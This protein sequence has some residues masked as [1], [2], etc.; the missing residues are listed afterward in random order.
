M[1]INKL[2]YFIYDLMIKTRVWIEANLYNFSDNKD[3]SKITNELYV[4]NLSTSTNKQLLKDQGITHVI[5]I[6]SEPAKHYLKDFKY[7]YI[8]AYDIPEFD[9]TY[10]L[11]ISNTFIKD[12]INRGASAII[13]GNKNATIM[14]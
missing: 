3:I 12:A 8:H 13:S 10:S 7:L 2:N 4:G 6:M 5:C 9:L 1:F 14:I 11:P